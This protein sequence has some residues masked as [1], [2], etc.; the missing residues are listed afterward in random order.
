MGLSERLMR[1]SHLAHGA[2]SRRL[3]LALLTT[4]IC[5]SAAP[6]SGQRISNSDYVAGR[7][8]WNAQNWLVASNHLSRFWLASK[9]T[10][11]YEV[12]FWLGTSWCRMVGKEA[13]GADLLD[14]ALSFNQM[15]E[16]ARPDRHQP[17]PSG[18]H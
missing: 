14:W 10:A 18:R 9:A 7:D 3:G 16:G 12:D 11:T 17:H 6:V 13:P 8:A 15:P 5:F 2:A 1:C 4:I